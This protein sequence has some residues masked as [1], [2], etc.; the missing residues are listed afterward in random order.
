MAPVEV[1]DLLLSK[2]LCKMHFIDTAGEGFIIQS[3]KASYV[4]CYSYD[5]SKK[6][7]ICKV[8]IY[9]GCHLKCSKVQRTIFSSE[10]AK[11]EEEAEN[12]NQPT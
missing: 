11:V 4:L 1:I 10:I 12:M 8:T 2:S 9:S 5:M 3:D 7:S 6:I